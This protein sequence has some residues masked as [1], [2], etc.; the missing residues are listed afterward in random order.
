[1]AIYTPRYVT[2]RRTE[3]W[4]LCDG[5]Q[6]ERC[7]KRDG[8]VFSCTLGEAVMKWRVPSDGEMI[9]CKLRNKMPSRCWGSATC[10]PLNAAEVV[11][12]TILIPHLV[13]LSR[14]WN[15]RIQDPGKLWLFGVPIQ[16]PLVPC[17]CRVKIGDFHFMLH[18]A[19]M[20][21]ILSF[22]FWKKHEKRVLGPVFPQQINLPLI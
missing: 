19:Y 5:W 20:I 16:Q 22:Q 13:F 7:L 9:L 12:P 14:I 21:T 1:M 15:H 11:N 17:M 4:S 2:Y 6:S 18:K 8:L 10:K 3:D